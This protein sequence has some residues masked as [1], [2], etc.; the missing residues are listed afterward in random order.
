MYDL[1]GKVALV[2]GAAG[3]RGMGRAI[4]VKLGAGGARVVVT[5]T[6]DALR[7]LTPEARAAGWRGLDSVVDELQAAGTDGFA[8]DCDIT[9]SS[10]VNTMVAAAFE[11]FGKIDILVNNAAISGPVDV[12]AANL[13]DAVWNKVLQINLS[14][15]FFVSRAVARHMIEQREG[16][17][18][19]NIASWVA[20]TG[21]AGMAAYC[22][23]KAGLLSLTQ[24][25]ALEL[26]RHNVRVNAVCPGGFPTD[27]N[28]DRI[29]RLAAEKGISI[30]DARQEH[31][32]SF[33]A[34]V[35][36][37]RPG[38]VREIA[39]VAAFLAS[40]HSSYVTGQAIN[41]DGGGLMA[42]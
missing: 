11:R 35:P 28:Y 37:G 27:L 3:M 24:T 14:G 39:D 17:K 2:T 36:F 34:R 42:R 18:I 7:S 29:A 22:A 41:V 15:P 8:V 32:A 21:V 1:R 4:A 23:A 16:G 19:I 26:A 12:H 40:D 13:D 30:D 6:S 38:D 9:D 5:D 20:K 25:M 10:A 33:G 31:I